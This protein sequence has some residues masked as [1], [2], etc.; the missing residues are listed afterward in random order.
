M[1]IKS[2]LIILTCGLIDVK[3]RN[4]LNPVWN[5]SVLKKTR[6]TL[7]AP[8][9]LSAAHFTRLCVALIPAWHSIKTEQS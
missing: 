5:I 1:N 8:L 6:R 4:S 7:H 2:S 3:I 9:T